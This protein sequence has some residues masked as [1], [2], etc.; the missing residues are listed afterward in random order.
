MNDIFNHHKRI[1]TDVFFGTTWKMTQ[2]VPKETNLK[3]EYISKLIALY[4]CTFSCFSW[5]RISKTFIRTNMFSLS[6]YKV[7]NIANTSCFATQS[8]KFRSFRKQRK[9]YHEVLRAIGLQNGKF[10]RLPIVSYVRYQ[11][12]RNAIQ[13][14]G[15]QMIYMRTWCDWKYTLF[16]RLPIYMYLTNRWS[17]VFFVSPIKCCFKFP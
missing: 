17:T 1:N 15:K 9:V 12:S 13:W 6:R 5:S 8:T 2:V 16:S 10:R 11:M 7:F 3:Y 14:H 4:S